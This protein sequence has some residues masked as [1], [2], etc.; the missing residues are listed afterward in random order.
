MKP[1]IN[2]LIYPMFSV[3][4]INLDS[5]FVLINKIVAR[6]KDRFNFFYILDQN[7]KPHPRSMI[8]NVKYLFIPM[9]K[10]K[11]KQVIYFNP[12]LFHEIFRKYP[13]QIIWNNVTE[14]GMNLKY[15]SDNI[16]EY[17][18]H[19]IFNYHHY[20]IHDS[21]ETASQYLPRIHIRN[22]Q[23]IS[24]CYVDFNYFH[25][26]HCYD[27]LMHEAKK[28]LS[29]ELM[30]QLE[31]NSHVHLGGYCDT[32]FNEKK[33]DE[34]TFI[35]NHRLDGYK[36]YMDTF[37][38][39]ERLHIEGRNFRVVITGNNEKVSRVMKYPFVIVKEL[40]DHNDYL[41]EL[42]RCH[43]NVTNSRHETYCISIAESMFHDHVIIAPNGVTF[44]ELLGDSYPFLFDN[45]EQQH[46]M[47]LRC[48]DENIRTYK[49][50]TK[51]LKLENHCEYLANQFESLYM[52]YG[53]LI[54]KMKDQPKQNRILNSFN[55]KKS[56]GFHD[57]MVIATKEF[58]TQAMPMQKISV[59]LNQ[60]GFSYDIRQEKFIR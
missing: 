49:H 15:T 18:R 16:V 42:S 33:Y 41:R 8:P 7:R 44:P 47:M 52:D 22:L 60:L 3:D 19:K 17:V 4:N 2:I 38:M 40:N 10:G 55:S 5:N 57:A 56:I 28:I 37:A 14:Q 59:L 35:Y 24:S 32:R 13:I 21:L 6:L 50:D 36:N 27:M 53:D 23:V 25:T 54:D 58:G 30:A 34:F 39:F 12:L 45:E 20:V 43:A 9:P 1:K 46:S 11:A 26:Q 51:R 29:T 48:L 31:K